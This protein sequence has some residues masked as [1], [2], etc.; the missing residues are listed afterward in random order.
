MAVPP[1]PQSILGY[2]CGDQPSDWMRKGQSV[3][4]SLT[5]N[6]TVAAEIIQMVAADPGVIAVDA[7]GN[8]FT[9]DV[10]G[11]KAVGTWRW[12]QAGPL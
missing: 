6:N 4:I 7:D 12:T 2:W 11:T 9:Y 3:F 8:L 1:N 10:A 5:G